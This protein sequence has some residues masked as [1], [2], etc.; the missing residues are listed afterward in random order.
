MES[1]AVFVLQKDIKRIVKMNLVCHKNL[2]HP[3]LQEERSY[4]YRT[5]NRS[6]S[7]RLKASSLIKQCR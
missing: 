7:P 1:K 4:G 6:R 3:L 5:H 2:N